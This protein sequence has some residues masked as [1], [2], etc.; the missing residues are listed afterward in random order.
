[1]ALPQRTV[2]RASPTPRSTRSATPALEL[3]IPQ[4][5][6]LN[7]P[8]KYKAYAAGFGLG[9]TFVGCMGI[10]MHCWQWPGISQ[11]YFAPTSADP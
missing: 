10:Y 8:H 3:N 9:K 1:M 4:A 11:G 2:G 5:N 7:L 6:F